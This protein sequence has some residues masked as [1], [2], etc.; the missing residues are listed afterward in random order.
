MKLFLNIEKENSY[1]R[2]DFS[3]FVARNENRCC[4]SLNIFSNDYTG[5]FLELLFYFYQYLSKEKM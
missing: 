4:L 1:L 2:T 3:D 5:L